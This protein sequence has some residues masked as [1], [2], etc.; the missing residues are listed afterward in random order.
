MAVQDETETMNDGGNGNGTIPNE[1]EAS[2]LLIQKKE[3][4]QLQRNFKTKWCLILFWERIVRMLPIRNHPIENAIFEG[5]ETMQAWSGSFLAMINVVGA[6]AMLVFLFKTMKNTHL[7]L[8]GQPTV[9][10]ENDTDEE[11]ERITIFEIVR[12]CNGID[13]AM[14]MLD[15]FEVLVPTFNINT[16]L[17][18]ATMHYEQGTIQVDGIYYLLKQQQRILH[19]YRT[20]FDAAVLGNC[21][22]RR[23]LTEL[24]YTDVNGCIH[25][26]ASIAS[27][28]VDSFEARL[29]TIF[30][31]QTDDADTKT[32]S[33]SS[34]SSDVAAAAAAAPAAAAVAAVAVATPPPLPPP[35]PTGTTTTLFQKACTGLGRKTGLEL[36][37]ETLGRSSQSVNTRRAL[38]YAVTTNTNEHRSANNNKE[39]HLD[40]I[41][42][43]CC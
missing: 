7:L 27:A 29:A 4:Q 20:L 11:L 9:V 16:A 25:H 23:F 31:F 1:R 30:T 13:N 42:F 26:C 15:A 10:D 22:S 8:N 5:G 14:R 17:L 21:F 12:E 41:F 39:I 43:Y 18:L 36:L 33:S 34:S 38:V 24:D 28:R 40:Y 37:E 32:T 2:L 35:P 19:K 3:L 6:E